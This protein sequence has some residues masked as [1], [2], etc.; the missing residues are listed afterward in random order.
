MIRHRKP[1]KRLRLIDDPRGSP[2]YMRK[3][4]RVYRIPEKNHLTPDEARIKR[5]LKERACEAD[6]LKCLF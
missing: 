3:Y 4:M 1:R 5:T 6:L 2:A